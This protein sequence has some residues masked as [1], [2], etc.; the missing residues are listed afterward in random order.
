FSHALQFRQAKL[1][2]PNVYLIGVNNDEQVK[3]YTFKCV[4]DYAER[5]ESVRPCRWVDEVVPDAPW[6]IDAAFIQKYNIDYVAHDEEPY[7]STGNED[8]YDLLSK[9]TPT[10]RIPGVSTSALLERVV[11]SYRR[12]DFDRK[13]EKMGHT[14]LMAQG[15]DYEDKGV[16]DE[17]SSGGKL[18]R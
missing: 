13:L 8:V 4:V 12:R 2:F 15:S 17:G 5:C 3:E 6:V 14:E 11:K 1:S 10:R 7:L 18:S 16:S 9:F